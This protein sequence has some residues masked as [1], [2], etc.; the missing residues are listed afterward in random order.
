M[1]ALLELERVEARYGAAR[2]LNGVDLAIA[3]GERVALL[4]RNGVGKTTVVNTL[5]ATAVKCGGEIRVRGER[6]DRI[7]G[8]TAATLGIAVVPQ[9]RKIL[10]NLSI[11]ENLKLGAALRR[12]GPWTL[13]AVYGLFPIL[14]ERRH[15]PGTA[16]SGGQQQML[17]IGRALMTN[18]DLL[19][20]DEAT[21][22]LAPLI[23]QQIWK[24]LDVLKATGLAMIVIDK[25]LEALVGFADR[26]VV[27]EK[28]EVVWRGTTPELLADASIQETYLSV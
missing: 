7:A 8:H 2:I 26:H 17:A 5:L 14:R 19:I 16:L 6:I 1:T 24:A 25:E 23:R 12:K 11:Q 4:G 10:P 15:T 3:P 22:G 9:G 21:E 27:M 20:L 13:D 28:G 18:P